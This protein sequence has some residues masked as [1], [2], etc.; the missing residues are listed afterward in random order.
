MIRVGQMKN[1]F[2]LSKITYFCEGGI[3]ILMLIMYF[4]LYWGYIIPFQLFLNHKISKQALA[5]SASSSEK[6]ST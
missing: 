3:R 2:G 4:L 5:V 6:V 1:N